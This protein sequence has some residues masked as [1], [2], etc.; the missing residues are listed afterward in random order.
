MMQTYEDE[1]RYY[2]PQSVET[3]SIMLFQ[4]IFNLHKETGLSLYDTILGGS[5]QSYGFILI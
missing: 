2:S 4:N 1:P 5:F 3:F